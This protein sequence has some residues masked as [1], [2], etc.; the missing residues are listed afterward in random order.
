M[1]RE[2]GAVLLAKL[3]SG[4]LAQGD[5]W[6]GGQTKNPWNTAEGSSGSSAGPA[7]ATAAGLVGFGIV[8]RFSGYRSRSVRPL[9]RYRTAANV[10]TREPVRRHGA[11]VDTG[12]AGSPVPL[13][14][15]LRPGQQRKRDCAARRSRFERLRKFLSTGTRILISAV[16]GWVISRTPSMK[17]VTRPQG[18]TREQAL[19]AQA[20]FRREAHSRDGSRW[21]RR[22]PGIRS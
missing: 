1:L 20:C 11:F 13:F 19:C 21:I 8:L 9:R 22:R 4:E 15:G 12:S 7:S 2:A 16:C 14:R 5:R 17:P 3:T 18:R 10:W 6:F